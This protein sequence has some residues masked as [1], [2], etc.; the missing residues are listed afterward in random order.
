MLSR[1]ADEHLRKRN[2][3]VFCFCGRARELRCAVSEERKEQKRM[4]TTTYLMPC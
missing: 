2:R 1:D 3:A 4:C